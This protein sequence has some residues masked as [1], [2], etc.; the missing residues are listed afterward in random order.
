MVVDLTDNLS[1]NTIIPKENHAA[2]R[3]GFSG[4]PANPR[5]NTSKYLAWK[6]G[7]MW[8]ESLAQGRMAVRDSMLVTATDREN[9]IQAQL[10]GSNTRVLS[11]KFPFWTKIKN[12]SYQTV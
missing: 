8:R 5:W 10:S 1:V 4:Y 6:T 7:A 9:E 3:A 12:T 11:F 2:L